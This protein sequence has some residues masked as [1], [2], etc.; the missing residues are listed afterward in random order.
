M[1]PS[2]IWMEV[3]PGFGS[4]MRCA[5]AWM[6][7]VPSGGDFD[8]NR[9]F[10]YRLVS[11]L[12]RSPNR[13]AAVCGP[14]K[15]PINLLTIGCR[16]RFQPSSTFLTSVIV[17]QAHRESPELLRRGHYTPE[18]SPPLPRTGPL[19]QP[20]AGHNLAMRSGTLRKSSRGTASLETWN[21]SRQAWRTSRP[22]VMISFT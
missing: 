2:Q 11:G 1:S 22:P 14:L 16:R 6:A 5:R 3:R 7:F 18:P 8:L 17:T 15:A 19:P 9:D 21:T 20:G 10:P 4:R 13:T 12:E